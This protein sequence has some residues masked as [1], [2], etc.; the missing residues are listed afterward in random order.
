VRSYGDEM[1]NFLLD[2][3]RR[4]AINVARAH[5]APEDPEIKVDPDFVP[6]TYN[7]PVW[8]ER[9][10]QLFVAVIGPT[11]VFVDETRSA[12]G[13]DFGEFPKMLGIPGVMYGLGAQPQALV[14][15]VSA[16][17]LPSLHS[18]RFAPDAA[19]TLGAGI[20]LFALAILEGLASAP[21]PKVQAAHD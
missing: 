14:D 1:R 13:E 19:A 9:L 20:P 4:V 5:A 21:L 6:S 17:D 12:G 3:I 2:E 8:I 15:K 18:D 7:D 16:A 10:R 11:R